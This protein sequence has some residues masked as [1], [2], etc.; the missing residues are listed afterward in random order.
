M[1]PE[2]QKR[3]MR[4]LQASLRHRAKGRCRV[5]PFRCVSGPFA[6]EDIYLTSYPTGTA[7]FRVG[8]WHGR[9]MPST[10]YH[11]RAP[12]GREMIYWEAVL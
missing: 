1:S 11:R 12:D 7:F 4:N 8:D 3:K 9:Y 10:E 2:E 6:G 5:Y